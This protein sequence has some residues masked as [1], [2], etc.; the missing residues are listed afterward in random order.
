MGEAMSRR[1]EPWNWIQPRVLLSLLIGCGLRRVEPMTL[2]VED[3]QFQEAA[4]LEKSKGSHPRMTPFD[5]LCSRGP[6]T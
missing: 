2:R 1:L 6:L 5:V 4:A 3:F